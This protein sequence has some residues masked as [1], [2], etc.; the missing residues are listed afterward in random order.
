MKGLIKQRLNN[1]SLDNAIEINNANNVFY[2]NIHLEALQ[3]AEC[4][5]ERDYAMKKML[6]IMPFVQ[7][8]SDVV[9]QKLITFVNL[10]AS[11]AVEGLLKNNLVKDM[12]CLMDINEAFT[13]EDKR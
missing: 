2:I 10:A 7:I 4:M 9:K 11:L 12:F 1:L 13:I 3:D 5:E 8:G 6:F